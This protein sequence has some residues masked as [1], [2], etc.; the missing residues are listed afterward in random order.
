MVDQ[1]PLDELDGEQVVGAAQRRAGAADAGAPGDRDEQ[2]RAER[3][4]AYVLDADEAQHG[5]HDRH[6]GRGHHGVGQDGA[7]NRRDH[8]PHHEVLPR[9]GAEAQKRHQRDAPVQSPPLPQ[10]G[11]HVRAEDEDHELF[12]IGRKDGG[13]RHEIEDGQ[14]HDGQERRDRQVDGLGHPPPRHPDQQAEAGADGIGASPSGSAA[15]T[16][17][18]AGPPRVCSVRRA[19]PQSARAACQASR[20]L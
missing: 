20:Y 15:S 13:D 19:W 10:R 7:E 11:K 18:A 17:N 5:E 1:L 14:N 12:G 16:R 8:E 4:L 6:H 9:A 3:A 2:C